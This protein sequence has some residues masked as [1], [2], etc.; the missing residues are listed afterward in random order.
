[1]D[2]VFLNEANRNRLKLLGLEEVAV[3]V[4]LPG[5]LHDAKEFPRHEGGERASLSIGKAAAMLPRAT[6]NAV[7]ANFCSCTELT[8]VLTFGARLAWTQ[9]CK[10][11]LRSFCIL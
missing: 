4:L 6:N 11:L 1:M 8:N 7:L 5:V 9:S 2:E 3:V 10:S